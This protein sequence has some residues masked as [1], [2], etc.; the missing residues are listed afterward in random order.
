MSSRPVIT[1]ENQANKLL[2]YS[3]FPNTNDRHKFLIRAE[4]KRPIREKGRTIFIYSVFMSFILGLFM[5][6]LVLVI[7]KKIIISPITALTDHALEVSK[8]GDLSAR[9]HL[10]RNDE[11]GLLGREIN[12]MIRLME[13]QTTELAGMNKQLKT[14]IEKRKCVERELRDSEARFRGLHEASSSGIV[15]HDQGKIIDAN[16]ALS[17]ITGYTPRELISMDGYKLIAPSRQKI[18]KSKIAEGD[19]TPYD[20]EGLRKNGSVYSLEIQARAVPYKGRMVRVTEFRDITA[21][22][23]MARQLKKTLNE[24]TAIIENSQV[25]IMFLKGSRILHKGNQRL[26]DILG[27]ETPESMGGL[28]MQELHLSRELFEEFGEKH[29]NHLVHGE[30]IQVE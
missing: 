25:G 1:S 19:E 23:L 2:V 28:R 6:L 20:V 18:M 15:I 24:L 4:L 5:A 11:F 29:F 21:R 8:S 7:F 13:Q 17:N 30:Q 14:D 9:I 22:I 10:P 12:R 27:Y 26:A 3:L 16:Q